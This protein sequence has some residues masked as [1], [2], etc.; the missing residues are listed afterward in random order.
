MIYK[1][2]M[3]VIERWHL[4]SGKL[5]NYPEKFRGGIE[6]IITGRSV[7]QFSYFLGTDLGREVV[8]YKGAPQ[9]ISLVSV[10]VELSII[11]FI[12]LPKTY[13]YLGISLILFH[14]GIKI[15]MDISFWHLI[16]LFP[17][18]FIYSKTGYKIESK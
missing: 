11:I 10:L 16:A 9:V 6:W 3:K 14:L 15:I 12:F 2:K 8:S 18:L 13:R 1:R 5:V 17:A 7:Q 4:R